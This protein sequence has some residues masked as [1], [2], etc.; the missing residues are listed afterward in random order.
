MSAGT[1]PGPTL[2]A[3]DTATETLCLAVCHGGQVHTHQEAGGAAASARLL[4]AA[5]ALLARA[6]TALEALDGIAFVQGPGAFTGLR[7]AC[8]VAQGLGY[9]LGR[10]LLPLDGLLLVADD[11]ATAVSGGKRPFEVLVAMDARMDEIYAGRYRLVAH[12]A[13]EE[14][15][16]L[17]LD[18]CEHAPAA[19]RWEVAETPALWTLD[20]LSEA[21]ARWSVDLIAGSALAAFDER[22][23]WPPAALRVAQPRDRGAA[24][25]RLALAAWTD[26]AQVAAADGMPLY[27]RD[28]VASTSAERAQALA[29]RAA[30]LPDDTA[31]ASSPAGAA[32]AP[33]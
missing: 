2:L 3:L 25:A 26:G 15:G 12:D 8:A 21:C 27:L 29:A 14:A 19:T 17:R 1:L 16:L 20:A 4:P 18:R 31:A 24:L 6:G 5:R 10:P 28:K 11:A 22:V 32:G 30:A 13:C 7:T 9:G 23:H 33:R